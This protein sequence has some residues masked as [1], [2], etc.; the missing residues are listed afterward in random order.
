MV[1]SFP[2]KVSG[3]PAGRAAEEDRRPR[4]S[5]VRLRERQQADGGGERHS[6]AQFN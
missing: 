3:R 1:I 4:G 2:S 5:A 6:G